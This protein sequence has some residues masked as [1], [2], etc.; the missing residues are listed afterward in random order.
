M[1]YTF[2]EIDYTKEAANSELF[3]NNFKDL[4]YVKVP[5]IYWEYTTPQ[6]II[7]Y[8]HCFTIYEAL[9]LN[10]IFNIQFFAGPYNGVCPWD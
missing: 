8:D 1:C 3:A 5:S 6:V 4:E 7:T 2:Q 10:A 9:R